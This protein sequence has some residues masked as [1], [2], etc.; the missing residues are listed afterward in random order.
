MQLVMARDAAEACEPIL[1]DS[2][3]L[4]ARS[5]YFRSA[6]SGEYG[7]DLAVDRSAQPADAVEFADSD[8]ESEDDD[9]DDGEDDGDDADKPGGGGNGESGEA[10]GNCTDSSDANATSIA[11]DSSAEVKP[12]RQS[13]PLIGLA[14]SARSDRKRV[15]IRNYARSTVLAWIHWL[16]T[17][18]IEFAPPLVLGRDIRN[19]VIRR[20]KKAFPDRVPPVS[21][22]SIYRIAEQY[23][24]HP[25]CLLM[26]QTRL[27]DACSAGTRLDSRFASSRHRRVHGAHA[28]AHVTLMS[29]LFDDHVL[30]LPG[31][32][33]VIVPWCAARL[34]AIR[35]TPAW[36][37]CL[38]L[39]AAGEL[40]CRA[41]IASRLLEAIPV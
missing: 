33:D 16:T 37:R 41:P 36:A 9:G 38:E 12:S 8:C 1:A 2:Q 19:V 5:S 40:P 7:D 25:P 26:A 13:T 21:A 3:L 4:S 18:E 15:V 34:G 39:E 29:Q 6:L 22:Q 17:G 24:P 14:S 32:A 28:L 11:D 35:A 23:V 31:I 30:H 20:F 27:P 10:P